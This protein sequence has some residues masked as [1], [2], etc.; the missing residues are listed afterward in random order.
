MEVMKMY[1]CFIAK[2]F[3]LSIYFELYIK[4]VRRITINASF[5]INH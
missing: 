5:L 1:I 4:N 3:F 2:V